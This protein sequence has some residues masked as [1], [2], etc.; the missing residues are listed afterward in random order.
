MIL[1]GNCDVRYLMTQE[2]HS[3]NNIEYL[4]IK[5]WLL[6]LLIISIFW[7]NIFSQCT[8]H[9]LGQLLLVEIDGLTFCRSFRDE[10]PVTDLTKSGADAKVSTTHREIYTDLLKILSSLRMIFFRNFIYL[11]FLSNSK[12]SV[13]QPKSLLP[14]QMGRIKRAMTGQLREWLMEILRHHPLYIVLRSLTKSNLVRTMARLW[15]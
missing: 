6:Q 2:F 13:I 15:Q 5:T 14:F 9:L 10:Q 12:Q 7:P 11:K 3:V 8:F 4:W 1:L